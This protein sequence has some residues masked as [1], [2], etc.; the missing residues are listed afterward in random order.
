MATTPKTCLLASILA[1]TVALTL[2]LAATGCRSQVSE[3]TAPYGNA[4]VGSRDAPGGQ[5][6]ADQTVERV[7]QKADEEAYERLRG[8]VSLSCHKWRGMYVTQDLRHRSGLSIV[9]LPSEAAY[10]EAV[11]VTLEASTRI[12]YVLDRVCEQT[13]TLW[14]VEDG[15]VVI[16]APAALRGY[17]TRVYSVG[18]LLVCFGPWPPD[19][20]AA[21]Q[22]APEDIRAQARLLVILTTQACAPVTWDEP[23]SGHPWPTAGGHVQLMD[24]DPHLLVVVQKAE[25][26]EEIEKLLAHLRKALRDRTTHGAAGVAP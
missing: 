3:A 13:G 1:G 23:A 17:Q 21:V 2:A 12:G 25:V 15:V 8:V 16:G 19:Q 4:A 20:G 6:P 22:A 10:P 5:E 7:S 14:R 11:P 9:W 18:D 24:A 26:H